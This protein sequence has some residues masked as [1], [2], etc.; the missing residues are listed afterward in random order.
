MALLD[1]QGVAP[2]RGQRVAFGQANKGAH[3]LCIGEITD[4]AA[5]TVLIRWERPAERWERDRAPSGYVTEIARRGNAA[6]VVLP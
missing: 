3:P 5:K 4:I 6:F 2:E 1:A